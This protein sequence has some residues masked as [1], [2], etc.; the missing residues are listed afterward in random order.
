MTIVRDHESFGLF[1]SFNKNEDELFQNAIS[2]GNRFTIHTIIMNRIIRAFWFK[3]YEEAAALA[4][5][6]A[7]IQNLGFVHVM[8]V[9]Y[10]GMSALHCARIHPNEPKWMEAAENTALASFRM[11]A[12][13]MNGDVDKATRHLT[14]ARACYDKW[15]ARALV[16]L[17][18]QHL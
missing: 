1:D 14:D 16:H 7:G 17:L 4:N 8:H 15:G 13:H 6:Y 18:G 10:C 12:Q 11:W 9:F 5:E 3:R 2:E